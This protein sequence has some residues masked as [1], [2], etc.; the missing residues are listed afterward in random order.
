MLPIPKNLDHLSTW[1]WWTVLAVSLLYALNALPAVAAH[2]ALV[3]ATSVFIGGFLLQSQRPA[4]KGRTRIQTIFESG[5]IG[6][7]VLPL[8]LITVA[9]LLRPPATSSYI[10]TVA[11]AALVPLVYLARAKA[12]RV[13]TVKNNYGLPSVSATRQLMLGFAALLL[14]LGVFL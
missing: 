12:P 10:A 14:T 3:L 13:Q 9:C 1:S 5:H 2:G 8:T 7:H 4:E 6:Q 11:L